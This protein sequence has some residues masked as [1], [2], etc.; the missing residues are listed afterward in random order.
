MK[1]NFN[2]PA[3]DPYTLL[4]Q[5]LDR[6]PVGFPATA[7]GAEI[8]ILKHIFT[9]DQAL[10]AA[11]LS[12]R[13]EPLED[14]HG[15]ACHLVP[16]LQD[17]QVQLTSMV[18]KGGIELH[19]AHGRTLYCNAP[20]VVGMYELQVDRLTPEFIQDFKIYSGDKRFGLAFLG[21]RLPQMRT[22]PIQKS[23]QPQTP[24]SPFD[25]IHDLL[26][27][28]EGPFV[29]LDCICRKKNVL[30]GGACKKTQRQETCLALGP[31]AGSV[32]GMGV[33]REISRTE[34]RAIMDEN[35]KEG[36]VLQPA[37]AKNPDFICS[38]CS[39]CCGMLSIQRSL[40]VPVNFWASNFQAVIDK[41]LCTGCGIC[42]KKCQADAIVTPSPGNGQK[43]R[44]A[45]VDKNRCIG[46]GLCIPACPV[47][48]VILNP[49]PRI[50]LPPDTRQDLHEILLAGKK[51]GLGKVKLYTRLARD[52]IR[53]G[54]LRLVQKN[55]R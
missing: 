47:Q 53:T 39:C 25:G 37:N 40:P 45:V 11:C 33:G 6:Q 10:I 21:T 17:L 34:A 51:E 22:I 15:R 12:H 49:K 2:H 1:K 44:S 28:A 43:P 41:R 32:L 30:Q 3:P 48:A 23:I 36:L 7:S 8:R 20:L 35:Q 24:V 29:I 5:H 54:D 19:Q 46:C 16:S 31:I 55:G 13:P 50:T 38:C 26:E 52:I 27:N 42:Q 14:V 9:P 4:Q 18:Q